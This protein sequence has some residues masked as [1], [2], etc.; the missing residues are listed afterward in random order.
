MVVHGYLGEALL[1][2]Q[3]RLPERE[4]LG[5]ATKQLLSTF[6]PTLHEHL[7][8]VLCYECPVIGLIEVTKLANTC[9]KGWSISQLD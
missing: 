1:P 8:K 3:H 4:H 2:V 6:Q 7:P 9:I 5:A